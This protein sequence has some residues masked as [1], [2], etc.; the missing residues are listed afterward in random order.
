MFT[1]MIDSRNDTLISAF[2]FDS[3]RPGQI[4]AIEHVLAGRHTLV[5]MPTGAGKSLIY[6]YVALQHP[7][8]TLV[9]SPL[10]ALMKDQ[11]DRLMGRGMTATYINSTLRV[12]EQSRRLRAMAEGAVKLVYIA[13]E[14]LRSVQFQ[15]VLRRVK[16]GL[17]AIDEAHCISEWGHDFRPDYLHIATARKR[18]GAPVTVALTATATPQVQND[19]LHQLDLPTAQRVIT[20]FNR[21]NLSFEVRSTASVRAKLRALHALLADFKSGAAIIYAGTRNDTEKVAEFIQTKV[22]L[23]AQAYHAGLDAQTRSQIQEVFVTGDLAV[24]VA[25]NAFGMG[26][27]RSDVRLVIHYTLPGTLEAYYQEAGRAGR[28]GQPARAVLLYDPADRLLREWLIDNNVPTRNN[29]HAL[30]TALLALGSAEVWTSLPELSLATGLSDVQLKVGL[31]QLESAGMVQ[32]LGDTGLRTLLCIGQWNEAHAQTV[33]R[34]ARQRRSSSRAQLERMVAY[35][36]TNSCRRQILLD[37]FGD[38]SAIEAPRCCDNCAAQQ[39]SAALA[40]SDQEGD[41]ALRNHPSLAVMNALRQI[42]WGVGRDKLV[43]VLKGSQTQAMRQNGYQRLVCY[44]QLASLRSKQIE[45]LIERLIE[46]GYL[47]VVGSMRPVLQV[48]PQGEAALAA[49]TPVLTDLPELSM[50]DTQTRHTVGT[51]KTAFVQQSPSALATPS[52]RSSQTAGNTYDLTAELLAQGL[53]PAEIAATRNLTITTIYTHLTYLIE[54]ETL[55]LAAVVPDEVAVL[56]RVAIQQ[57]GGVTALAPIKELLPDSITY[58][59]IRCV[60]VVWRRETPETGVMTCETVKR[61][62][63]LFG[64]G[65]APDQIAA[66]HNLPLGT[67]YWHLA[68]LIGTGDLSLDAVIPDSI[69]TQVRAAIK[70][71]GNMTTPQSIK[72]YLPNTISDGQIRCVLEARRREQRK[73]KAALDS[74]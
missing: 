36:E 57:A 41:R 71:A 65:L 53:T 58:E 6:Q 2:G 43:Q 40:S 72:R 13:P 23:P 59:Q 24:V 73:A 70:Q 12:D 7:G 17:L 8:L 32:R 46:H 27:D 51:T 30:Y 14:R 25:T 1:S 39:T 35:A 34:N 48:T 61:T 29:V 54:N 19:I 56:I 74:R 10:I 4:E 55:S 47:K 21:S 3:F 44:G 62:A 49:Q 38:Q 28:D 26:I 67:I 66:Q 60:A 45:V 68:Q 37:H 50:F 64:Q 31:A 69:A 42:K 5:V 52:Q 33:A 9:I 15:Q 22:G 18:I 11:V 63:E 16:V 20:G